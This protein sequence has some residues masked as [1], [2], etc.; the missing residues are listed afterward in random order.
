MTVRHESSELA[1]VSVFADLDDAA[2]MQCA[3]SALRR[4]LFKGEPV[5]H[6]GDRPTRFHVLLSGWVRILQAGADGGL[7][8]VRFVGPGE[9]F[10]SFALFT[11]RGYPADAIAAADAVELSWTEAQ[12]RQLIDQYPSIAM[13]LMAVA[14]RRLADLQERVREISTQRSEPRIAN[15]L[16]RLAR[17][18]SEPRIDGGIEMLMP[19]ARKDIAAMSATTLHTAS[20]TMSA[21]QRCG[22]LASSRQ[23]ISIIKPTELKRIGD[24][25]D[26]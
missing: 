21:W 14:A 17:K 12:L 1:T 3:R 2:Q 16:L 13:N 22:I 24:G 18:G 23:R 11:E 25:S 19:L 7:S 4:L 26:S 20:R 8:V 6:Q 15:A 10:G 9:V 5:F